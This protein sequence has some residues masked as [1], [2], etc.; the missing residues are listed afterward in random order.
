[1]KSARAFIP[2][3]IPLA[4]LASVTAVGA[5]GKKMKPA[6][7]PSQSKEAAPAETDATKLRGNLVKSLTLYRESL[8]KILAM[9]ERDVN[10]LTEQVE[11]RRPLFQQGL[12]S[13]QDLEP[14]ERALAKARADAEETPSWITEA[15]FVIIEA[16]VRE[17][18]LKLPPLKTGGYAETASLIFYN[19]GAKWSLTDAGK[20]QKFFLDLFGRAL[21]VSAFGQTPVHDRMKFDHRD[22]MDVAIHPDSSEGR[23]LMEHLRKL[24]IPFL[25]YRNKVTGSATGAHIH[26]GKP[27]IKMPPCC[28]K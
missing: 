10:D 20:I 19:G 2:A 11:L 12:I 24:G 1:M 27:S 9:Y 17:E 4:L 26:I 7:E 16:M 15:D 3:V 6:P 18:L 5:Q 8:E 28:P 14:Y 25:A 23:A 22:A 21:P 13:K